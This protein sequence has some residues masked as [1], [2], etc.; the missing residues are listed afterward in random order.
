MNS[1]ASSETFP[2]LNERVLPVLS[3]D[4]V[5]SRCN[6]LVLWYVTFGMF[7]KLNFNFKA[8]ECSSA[9]L[10]YP[11]SLETPTQHFKLYEVST[12]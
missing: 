5:F 7:R 4:A 12:F 6:Q 2:L 3:Y 8:V 9:N 1:N 11:H 10:P